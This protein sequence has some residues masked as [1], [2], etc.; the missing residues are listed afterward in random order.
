MSTRAVPII[1]MMPIIPRLCKALQLGSQRPKVP[2][3]P[4]FRLQPISPRTLQRLLNAPLSIIHPNSLNMAL[5]MS[6][7]PIRLGVIPTTGRAFS[8]IT[9]FNQSPATNAGSAAEAPTEPLPSRWLPDVKSRIRKIQD[10]SPSKA[11]RANAI[12]QDLDNRWLDLIAGSE[13]FLTQPEWRG[14]DRREIIWGDIV[15]WNCQLR[16]YTWDMSG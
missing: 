11:D 5:R 8:S 10:S 14:L 3:A 6:R 4:V 13:G 2:T 9:R 16:L 1:P 12:S 15:R 7:V